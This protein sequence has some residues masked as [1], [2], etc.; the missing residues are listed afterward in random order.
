MF[1]A[2]GTASKNHH[3]FVIQSQESDVNPGYHIFFVIVGLCGGNCLFWTIIDSE[4]V[5]IFQYMTPEE[6]Y[7]LF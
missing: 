6:M 3:H 1:L 7:L 5:T 4:I 2:V